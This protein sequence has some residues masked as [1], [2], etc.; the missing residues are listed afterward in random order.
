MQK[1]II[2]AVFI[3]LLIFGCTDKVHESM[4]QWSLSSKQSL[5]YQ[6]QLLDEVKKEV[7]YERMELMQSYATYRQG[8]QDL[9]DSLE[10][11][12]LTG[13]QNFQDEELNAIYFIEKME[14]RKLM[15]QKETFERAYKK[16]LKVDSLQ[17]DDTYL[18]DSLVLGVRHNMVL[19]AEIELVNT[20]LQTF[21]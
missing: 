7:P 21:Y 1:T 14:L 18:R 13:I 16:I 17:L 8:M 11:G 5:A 19:Q 10:H 6:D 12:S 2:S 15:R 4:R 3:V 20:T 9:R